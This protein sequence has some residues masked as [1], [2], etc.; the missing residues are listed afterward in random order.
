MG[1]PSGKATGRRR[2]P[3]CDRTRATASHWEN[4]G[5]QIVL[6]SPCSVGLNPAG[7]AFRPETTVDLP[8]VEIRALLPEQR[9]L[10]D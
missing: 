6:P 8:L 9:C 3:Y 5:V 10:R 1:H 7:E 2:V 4:I